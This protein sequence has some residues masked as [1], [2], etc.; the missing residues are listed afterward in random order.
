MVSMMFILGGRKE[1]HH[2]GRGAPIMTITPPPRVCFSSSQFGCPF[3]VVNMLILAR[4]R[5]IPPHR[6]PG[7]II[8]DRSRVGQVNVFNRVII[9]KWKILHLVTD[10]EAILAAQNNQ[11]EYKHVV[12]TS[13]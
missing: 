13:F 6:Y 12:R 11:I 10:F 3:F 5:Q 7:C 8:C 1:A 4:T 2:V 9:L